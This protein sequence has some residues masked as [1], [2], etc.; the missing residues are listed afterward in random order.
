MLFTLLDHSALIC[1]TSKTWICTVFT[2]QKLYI[3]FMRF[4][5]SQGMLAQLSFDSIDTDVYIAATYTYLISFLVCCAL[6]SSRT[7]LC[8]SLVSEDMA[9]CINC[10]TSLYYRLWCQL[11]FLW[12]RQ[13]ISIKVTRSV[14][15]Q[16]ALLKC[17]NSQDFDEDII[18]ELLKFTRNVIYGAN[19]SSSMVE[20]CADKWKA[21]KRNP[22]F[23]FLQIQT[24][25]ANILFKQITWHI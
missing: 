11:K 17:G 15:A 4:Y 13:V 2:N 24:A 22:F 8:R 25:Y 21:M 18:D 14:A 16:H 6:R 9:R 5:V 3:L 20:A 19:K 7:I 10:K 1:Q 12:Q 23:K